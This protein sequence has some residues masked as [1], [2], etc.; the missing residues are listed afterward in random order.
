M[1]KQQLA[2]VRKTI[3]EKQAQ[4]KALH[5][6][7]YQKNTSLSDEENTTYDALENEVARLEK[8][9]T[10]IDT[11][12]KAAEAA[13]GNTNPVEGNDPLD[14]T[15]SN[16][17]QHPNNPRVEVSE[18]A[19]ENG[20]GF[21]L[22]VKAHVAAQRSGGAVSAMEILKSWNAPKPVQN[23]L[24]SKAQIGTTTD[25]DFAAA[26]VDSALLQNQFIEFL[27]P[28]TFFGKIEGFRKVPFN[29]K[30]AVQTS[31]GTVN[32][33]GEAKVKPK[34]SPKFGQATLSKAKIAGIV[35]LTDELIRDSSLDALTLVRDDLAKGIAQFTDTE[36]LNEG[37][38]ETDDSPA[39]IING[40]PAIP[41][42]GT[43]PEA[44]ATDL[45]AALVAL[46]LAS[47]G[48]TGSYWLMSETKFTELALLKTDLG[49]KVFDGMELGA[50]SRLLNIRVVVS[51]N[52]GDKIVLVKPSEILLAD[53]G[54]VDFAYSD[55]ATLTG[56]EEAVNLFEQ[57]MV[58]VRA[59]RHIRWKPARQA[60]VWID[61]SEGE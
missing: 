35:A 20:M 5:E 4:M 29:V 19:L 48:V 32:W 47:G 51:E 50:E 21:A 28:Q 14:S 60:A 39:G 1:L 38:A 57:N 43:T 3:A 27:R 34:T 46:S 45:Q 30:V 11:L 25:P 37:K 58:A 42:T 13:E 15:K 24:R 23:L 40:I 52:V 53:S 9:A 56:Y 55:S 8:E 33:V 49:I 54:S 26:L 61:Y 10:R 7:A 44:Y 36:F 18:P 16:N 22:A 41:S 31:G 2:R 12:I 6:G 17:P 59:E